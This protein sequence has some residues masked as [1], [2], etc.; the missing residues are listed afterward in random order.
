[1]DA[2]ASRRQLAAA[3]ARVAAGDRTALR[4]VYQDTSAKLFGI[5]LRILGDRREAD[6][7]LQD[8]YLTVWRRAA[9]FDA[10]RASPITW[11]VAVARNAVLTACAHPAEREVRPRWRQLAKSRIRRPTPW[12]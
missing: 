11:L 9:T 12:H 1:M 5:C 8:V 6:D 7:V 10:R 4:L 2:D 3:L